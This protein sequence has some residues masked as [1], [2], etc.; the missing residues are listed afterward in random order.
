MSNIVKTDGGSLASLLH[1]KG[2]GLCPRVRLCG[3]ARCAGRVF[4]HHC[5][6]PSAGAGGKKRAGC[7]RRGAAGHKGPAASLTWRAQGPCMCLHWPGPMCSTVIITA[8]SL[9]L[10]C[11][12]RWRR[13]QFRLRSAFWAPCAHGCILKHRQ[14]L[15][16]MGRAGCGCTVQGAFFPRVSAGGWRPALC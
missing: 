5:P 8:F 7:G 12:V 16:S 10:C 9:C 14:N 6:P 15:P 2:G 3:P 11:A 4:L 13:P 1:G